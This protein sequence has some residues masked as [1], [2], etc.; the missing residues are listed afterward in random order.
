MLS[1]TFVRPWL[2]RAGSIINLYTDSLRFILPVA[3]VNNTGLNSN[4][5]IMHRIDNFTMESV[6][7][8]SENPITTANISGNNT[9]SLFITGSSSL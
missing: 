9:L 4:Y 8:W 2:L 6:G 1:T 5:S 3:T 7:G